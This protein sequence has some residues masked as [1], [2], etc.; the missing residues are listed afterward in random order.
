MAGITAAAVKALREKTQLPMMECKRALQE[1]DG[2][3]D[4]AIDLLRKQGKKTMESRS[5]RET[6]FGRLA[7]YADVSAG[8]GAM[9]ELCCESAT[10]AGHEEFVQLTKD[11]ATQ[12]ATGPGAATPEELLAQPSIEAAAASSPSEDAASA[13]A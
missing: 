12:L 3:Q 4:A 9:I 6:A 10:V 7:I 8:V 11:L 5:G 1:T 13:Q 2:D